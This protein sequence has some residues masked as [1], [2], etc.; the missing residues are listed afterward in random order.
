MR[1][2]SLEIKKLIFTVVVKIFFIKMLFKAFY[3][4]GTNYYGVASLDFD[5]T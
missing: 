3:F 2:I 4:D 1:V 5:T